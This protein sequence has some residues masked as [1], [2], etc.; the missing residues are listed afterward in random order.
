MM[1]KLA[2]FLFVF[3]CTPTFSQTTNDILNMLVSSGVISREQADS[4]RNQA[5]LSQQQTETERKSFP[6]SSSRLLQVSGFIQIRAQVFD[7]KSKNDGFDLRRSRL[8]FKGNFSSFLTYRLQTDLANSPR[9]LDAYAEIKLKEYLVFTIGQFRIPFSLENLSSLNKF[10]VIDYSQAVDAFTARGKDV[11][12]NQNGRDIG[13]QAGGVILKKGDLSMVEYRLGIFNGSG[14]NIGDTANEAKDIAA[15]LLF[16]PVKQLS[17]GISYYDGWG[18]AIKPTS[19]FVGR[20]QERNRF[21]IEAVYSGSRLSFKGEYIQGK[22]G[23]TDRAGWYAMAGYY[24]V[25]A[26][27]QVVAKYDSY[28]PD[29][30]SD[31]NVNTNYSGG[32]NYNINSWSR[33]Q[34]FYTVREEQGTSINNNYLS[35]QYQIGF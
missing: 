23:N 3:I 2:F 14:M 12:G 29:T 27:L 8:D 22:D 10:E 34:A 24:L 25:P 30:D 35:V 17:F 26:K 5:T 9:I 4:L 21:G 33:V 16:N 15:R 31:D 32:I 19:E 1:N 7:E 13:I 28:D 11:I 18:K 20:S 6:L